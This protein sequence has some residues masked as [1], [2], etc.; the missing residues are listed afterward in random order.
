MQV[1]NHPA[2]CGFPFF[3]PFL[4]APN[5]VRMTAKRGTT[6]PPARSWG[7]LCRGVGTDAR[8]GLIDTTT[9]CYGP[10]QQKIVASAFFFCCAAML[11]RWGKQVLCCSWCYEGCCRSRGV[12]VFGWLAL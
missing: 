4:C 8:L 12:G 5:P 7:S 1:T 2:S 6:N 10:V 3:F 11:D 9:V